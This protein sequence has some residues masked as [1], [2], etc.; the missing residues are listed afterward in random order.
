MVTLNGKIIQLSS[1]NSGNSSDSEI[2]T[3][4]FEPIIKQYMFYDGGVG[5]STFKKLQHIHIF[6]PPKNINELYSLHLQLKIIVEQKIE[7]VKNYRACS[8]KLRQRITFSKKILV[9]HQQ[10][11]TI[12]A[13]FVNRYHK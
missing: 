6:S 12:A 2:I 10:C 4:E 1:S 13:V 11:W 5:D 7:Q 3:I 9:Q 8:H